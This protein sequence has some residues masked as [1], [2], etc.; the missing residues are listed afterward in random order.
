MRMSFSNKSDL[1]DAS[2]T[3]STASLFAGYPAIKE[4][5]FVEAPGLSDITSVPVPQRVG[6]RIVAVEIGLKLAF[7]PPFLIRVINADHTAGKGPIPV[8]WARS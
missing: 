2:D 3:G 6:N 1:S 5:I 7:A 4:G 8:R